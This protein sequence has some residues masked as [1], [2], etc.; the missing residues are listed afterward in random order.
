MRTLFYTIIMLMPLLGCTVKSQTKIQKSTSEKIDQLF[1]HVNEKTP[2]YMVGVI[3]D[4]DYLF[5][6]VMVWLIWNIISPLAQNQLLILLLFPTVY[7]CLCS[8]TYA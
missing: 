2:G 5:Q 7:C 4:S 8:N 1:K 6:K 3:Q